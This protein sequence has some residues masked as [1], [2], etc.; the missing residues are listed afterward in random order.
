M[1]QHITHR[2]AKSIGTSAKNYIPA[3]AFTRSIP[4]YSNGLHRISSSRKNFAQY[5]QF[6]MILSPMQYGDYAAMPASFRSNLRRSKTSTARLHFLAK[7]HNIP[8]ER[9]NF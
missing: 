7:R 3:R 5:A 8:T 6:R 2:R 4:N 1:G 9:Q